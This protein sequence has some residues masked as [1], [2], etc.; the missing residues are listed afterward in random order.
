MPDELEE[1]LARTLQAMPPAGG[2][3]TERALRAALAALPPAAEVRR[4]RRRR[5]LVPAVACV[6][7]F[8]FGGVTLAATGGRL[9][10]IGTSAHHR[11]DHGPAHP[12]AAHPAA[13]LPRGAIAFSAA[14]DGRAWLATSAGSALRGRSLAALAMS[15]GAVWALEGS[16][17][18]LRAVGIPGGQAGFTRPVAGTPVAAAWAP[19][20]IRIAY[21]VRTPHGDRLYDMYGNGTH[22]FLVAARASGQTPSWRWDSQAFAYVRAGGRVVVHDVIDGVTTAIPRGCGIRRAAAVAFAPYGGLLAIADRSGRVR[23]VDTI[24]H[25]RGM[26]TFGAA[27]GLPKIA[28]LDPRQLVVGMDDTITRYVVGLAGGADV[29]AV[30]GSVAGIVAAPGGRRIAL[31]LRDGS[32]RVRVVEART[33]RFSEASYPLRVYRVLLDL[34]H[35]SGPVGLTWQ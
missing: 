16:G 8:V 4:R 12:P 28:W 13:V 35:A 30:P 17:S 1:R 3:A 22:A 25:T 31:A 27:S 15:P 23:V 9:P 2:D 21:V 29:T 11:H 10:L 5:L 7:A 14:A 26:C 33:P 34:G 6:V 20:G 19:A 18:S 32:G 24:R